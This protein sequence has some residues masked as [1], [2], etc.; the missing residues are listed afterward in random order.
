MKSFFS[1]FK[2]TKQDILI[3]AVSLVGMALSHWATGAK[4]EREA[5]VQQEEMQKM[6]QE[7]VA[8]QIAE[9]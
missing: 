5:K 8:K 3:G 7:E 2:I 6:I 4:A 9:R 1:S